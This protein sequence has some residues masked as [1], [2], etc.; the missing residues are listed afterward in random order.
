MAHYPALSYWAAAGVGHLVGSGLVAMW[1]LCLIAIYIAYY[2]LFRLLSN[3]QAILP[4]I[5]F[6][7]C[8]PVLSRFS[9]FFGFETVDN[10]FYPQLI[11]S[12]VY[13][14]FLVYLSLESSF[15]TWK[16]L[17]VACAVSCV[18]MSIHA[19]PALEILATFG[20]ILVFSIAEKFIATRQIGSTADWIRLGFFVVFCLSLILFDQ[21]FSSLREFS[22]N[23]G[24]IA[25]GIG[26]LPLGILTISIVVILVRELIY[27]RIDNRITRSNFLFL[28][29]IIAAG[30]LIVLQYLSLLLF[31]EG[32]VYAI[33]KHTY[34]VFSLSTVACFYVLA[35]RMQ[36][37]IGRYVKRQ[38]VPVSVVIVVGSALMTTSI[39]KGPDWLRSGI[40]LYPIIRQIN[41]AENAVATSHPNF[42]PGNTAVVAPNVNLV[43]RYLITTTAFQ[44]KVSELPAVGIL[45]NKFD[46]RKSVEYVMVQSTSEQ[47][48]SCN[49]RYAET[50]K[51][52]IVPISCLKE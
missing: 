29:A 28:S 10:F 7:L 2:F 27:F 17:F 25:I 30:C 32:S 14:G 31:N 22:K 33:Q 50:S 19:L 8:T 38:F 11:G 36:P 18:T 23:N 51:F 16:S 44:M 46:A 15:A 40:D 47:N 39:L 5:L 42:K 21:D 3:D 52:S 41:Y 20:V 1:L 13:C 45:N 6:L 24:S 43:I 12:A 49:V 26:F 34:F 9:A 4:I 37:Y 48:R 35:Y